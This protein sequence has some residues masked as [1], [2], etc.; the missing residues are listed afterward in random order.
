MTDCSSVV[1]W[2]QIVLAWKTLPPTYIAVLRHVIPDKHELMLVREARVNMRK[3]KSMAKNKQ[4]HSIRVR[5][6]KPGCG[7]EQDGGKY[8]FTT[9]AEVCA[10]LRGVD[11]AI[12]WM[13][14][15]LIGDVPESVELNEVYESFASLAA[16][17]RAQAAE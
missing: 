4:Q 1:K 10:F 14:Y 17:K 15:V 3:S 7:D 8:T 6:G 12:G 5:W 9:E 13:E 2:I 11:D 16:W